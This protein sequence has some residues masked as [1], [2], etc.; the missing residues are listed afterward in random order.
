MS[1]TYTLATDAYNQIKNIILDGGVKPGEKLKGEYLKNLLGMGLS[2]I[3]EGLS[4]LSLTGFVDFSDKVGF[5][6]AIIN[7]HKIYDVFET[8]AKIEGLLLSESMQKGN[9]AWEANVLSNL[10][11]LSKVENR[12]G[13]HSYSEWF[14][15]NEEFHNALIAASTSEYLTS[16]RNQCLEIKNWFLHLAFK[17]VDDT[18]LTTN[19]NEHKR[20]ADLAILRDKTVLNK[21]YAHNTN[22]IESLVIKLRAKNYL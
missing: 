19:H 3:R 11:R 8:F 1:K 16:L 12:N 2:P 9:D 14:E 15:R 7:R 10:Y 4:K 21:L 13:Q 17:D 18:T 22:S 5:Q 20:I 6:V